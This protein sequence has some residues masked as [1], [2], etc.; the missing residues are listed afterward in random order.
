MRLVPSQL[1]GYRI[2]QYSGEI[3]MTETIQTVTIDSP[4]YPVLLKEIHRPPET[5]W[6]RGA[7]LK[8]GE[9]CLAVVGTR[10]PT[11]Y[12]EAVTPPLVEEL[13]AAG[14][15]IVSGLA[16]GVDTMAHRAAL[17]AG[18]RTIAVLGSGMDHKSLFPPENRE[19]M[20]SI[21]AAGGL[22]ISEF[23]E[24]TPARKEHFPQRNRIIA[25]LSVGV[26]VIEAPTRS[27]ALITTRYAT[28]Q[29]REVFATPGPIN[30]PYSWGP[31]WL[32]QQGAHPVL[33]AQDVFDVLGVAKPALAVDVTM[34]DTST[35]EADADTLE[36]HLSFHPIHIDELIRKTGR[37]AHVINTR[38]AALEIE[39]KVRH[40][41]GG[42]YVRI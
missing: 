28:E 3:V 15:T 2:R 29:N 24:G 10:K 42:R 12:A 11:Y 40:I 9:N 16:L 17:K 19:L 27:G 4:E 20:E 8:N 33:K 36:S 25:G 39:G 32:I 26:L 5:L 37:P 23:P 35:P 6:A 7:W 1:H 18:G 22:V 41:G 34:T 38:L 30:S 31:N 13:A 14:L 21:I